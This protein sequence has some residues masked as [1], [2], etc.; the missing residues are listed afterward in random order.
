MTVLTAYDLK[1]CRK[2]LDKQ[3]S[4]YMSLWKVLTSIITSM[5]LM[6]GEVNRLR[7]R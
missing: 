3:F 5:T 7:L 2:M 6:L 1:P 4:I